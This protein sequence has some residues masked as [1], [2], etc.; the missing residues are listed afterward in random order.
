MSGLTYRILLVG[1]L[2]VLGMLAIVPRV[3][4]Q[5]PRTLDIDVVFTFE[6]FEIVPAVGNEP[7]S[8]PQR[9]DVFSGQGAVYEAGDRTTRIG[10][11]YFM[12]VGTTEARHFSTAA[13]YMYGIGHIEI[14]G[15]GTFGATGLVTAVETT[16][17]AIT[18]GTGAFAMAHGQCLYQPKEGYDHWTCEIQ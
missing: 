16:W 3:A 2:V 14:W 11:F 7:L 17:F 9:G 15:E 5:D 13:N 1:A 8:F 18:G 12:D 10:T 4:S 6:S